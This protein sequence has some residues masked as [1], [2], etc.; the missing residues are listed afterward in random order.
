MKDVLTIPVMMYPKR[1]A[2]ACMYPVYNV[3]KLDEDLYLCNLAGT[4]KNKK[5]CY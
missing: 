3:N 1:R 2:I 4:V 5:L